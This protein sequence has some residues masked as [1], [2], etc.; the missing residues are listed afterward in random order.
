[1]PFATAT[2]RTFSELG[3][4]SI[5][6]ATAVAAHAY[7]LSSAA[8]ASRARGD[9]KVSRARQV[10]M[11]LAYV[12]LDL[13]T[14]QIAKAFRRDHSTVSHAC[15]LIEEAREDPNIDRTMDWLETLLRRS[16]GMAA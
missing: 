9:S 10:A 8:V 7:G 14:R 15:R 11:Y 2:N 16:A 12:V 5:G 4:G 6:L 13:T 1:M 3:T